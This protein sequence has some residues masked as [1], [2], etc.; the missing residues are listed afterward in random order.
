MSYLL[1]VEL[2][3][4]CEHFTTCSFESFLKRGE[5]NRER[6]RREERGRRRRKRNLV[7]W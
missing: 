7:K 6:E 1:V 4:S 3:C 5:S 2:H